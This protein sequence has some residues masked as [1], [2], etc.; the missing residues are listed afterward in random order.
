LKNGYF[1]QVSK[2]TGRVLRIK[3]AYLEDLKKYNLTD[4]IK[5]ITA[6]AYL[7]VGLK[8]TNWHIENN[9]KLYELLRCKKELMLLPDIPHDLANTPQ[10]KETFIK[11]LLKIIK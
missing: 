9:K 4:I 2:S 5:E 11:A 3:K 7:I 1:D 8:D 6:Y 10:N